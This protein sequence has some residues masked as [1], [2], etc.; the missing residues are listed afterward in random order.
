M[1][2]CT[3]LCVCALCICACACSTEVL[4]R[5][6]G[7]GQGGVINQDRREQHPGIPCVKVLLGAVGSLA[8]IPLWSEHQLRT[9][10]LHSSAEAGKTTF[11]SLAL[12]QTLWNKGLGGLRSS[13]LLVSANN[14]YLVHTWEVANV[15]V[16]HHH[17]LWLWQL[18][19][20]KEDR[21]QAICKQLY[22]TMH[23]VKQGQLC[24]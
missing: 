8:R 6:H 24:T 4:V 21:D 15:C 20:R 17:N 13:S 2:I 7:R 14:I 3:L 1:C 23:I 19:Q 9:V 18:R 10:L 12:H 22:I 11:C 5:T 16:L